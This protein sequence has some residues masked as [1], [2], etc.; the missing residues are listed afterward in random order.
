MKDLD[1]QIE[2]AEIT[3]NGEE[4][5]VWTTIGTDILVHVAVEQTLIF[6]N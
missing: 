4:K 1:L 5:S 2:M 6:Y 3:M